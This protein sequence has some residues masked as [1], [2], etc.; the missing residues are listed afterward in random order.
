MFT[1]IPPHD[2]L[3]LDFVHD[4][5][6]EGG[7]YVSCRRPGS[8]MNGL[9]PFAIPQPPA[10]SDPPQ[11]PTAS[12]PPQPP[13]ASDPPIPGADVLSYGTGHSKP[14]QRKRGRLTESDAQAVLAAKEKILAI[15]EALDLELE[16]GGPDG[17]WRAM[18]LSQRPERAS[19]LWNAFQAQH[20]NQKGKGDSESLFLQIAMEPTSDIVL[21]STKV[22]K[23]KIKD[24]YESWIA[25]LDTLDPTVR[26]DESSNLLTWHTTKILE[27][28]LGRIH[29]PGGRAKK[30]EKIKEELGQEVNIPCYR[31]KISY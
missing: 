5:V 21:V 9:P 12:D 25:H 24:D 6:G 8:N 27:D 4:M 3:S 29:L 28:E 15:V 18:G 19:Q 20:A 13:A 1:K 7:T 30:M 14:K 22:Y 2:H 10:T 31:L 17:V 23:D 11:P 26:A 16:L